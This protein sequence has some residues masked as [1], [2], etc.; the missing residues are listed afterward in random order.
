MTAWVR[1]VIARLRGMVAF[2][3]R[4][5]AAV[6]RMTRLIRRS[7]AMARRMARHIRRSKAMTRRMAALMRHSRAMTRRMAA[8]I[9]VAMPSTRRADALERA[10]PSNT[11]YDFGM[12]RVTATLDSQTLAKIR[13]VA[14]PLGVSSFLNEAARERLAR[15]NLRGSLDDLDVKHGPVPAEVRAEVARE[16]KRLFRAK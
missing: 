2:I 4:L 7:G 3:R 11:P 5:R 6:R 16:A 15:L 14:G 12:A 9:R 13:R 8:F 1:R 10:S